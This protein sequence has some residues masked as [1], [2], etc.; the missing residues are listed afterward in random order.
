MRGEQTRNA[1]IISCEESVFKA[2]SCLSP[3][4]YKGSISTFL[5]VSFFVPLEKGML[6]HLPDF[7]LLF[8]EVQVKFYHASK[9]SG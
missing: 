1:S 8:V 3:G 2:G 6:T 5:F 7:R 9:K 4:S